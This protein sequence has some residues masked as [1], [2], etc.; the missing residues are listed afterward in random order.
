[1]AIEIDAWFE[2][3]DE[4]AP[5]SKLTIKMTKQVQNCWVTFKSS[6]NLRHHQLQQRRFMGFVPGRL[7][8]CRQN[9]TRDCVDVTDLKTD[10]EDG[11]DLV[12]SRSAASQERGDCV[13]VVVDGGNDVFGVV[14][15]LLLWLI[16]RFESVFLRSRAIFDRS[17][18]AGFG[19]VD[20]PGVSVRFWICKNIVFTF[21][22]ERF[23]NFSVTLH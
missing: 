10:V 4:F 18:F 20:L 12:P 7:T 1:M 22:S 15:A 11:V 5:L 16:F 17:I 13:G 3:L 14:D 19:L 21:C 23:L 6:C 8:V 2:D 9:I